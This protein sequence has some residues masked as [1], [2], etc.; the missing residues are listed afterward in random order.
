MVAGVA[1]SLLVAA[2]PARA[3][4]AAPGPQPPGPAS[5]VGVLH[6]YAVPTVMV[7][8]MFGSATGYESGSG[9]MGAFDLRVSVGGMVQTSRAWRV[10]LGLVTDLMIPFERSYE[11]T[12]VYSQGVLSVFGIEAELERTLANQW[13]IGGR[14]SG[15]VGKAETGQWLMLGARARKGSAFAGVDLLLG[16]QATDYETSKAYGVL[17]GGGLE[18]RPGRN[19]V[20]GEAGL[21]ALLSVLYV[22]V[23]QHLVD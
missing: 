10:R 6:G 9:R 22:V 7:G 8:G 2:V 20:L 16:R 13:R 1:M 18:G 5:A 14:A 21:V 4:P 15:E 23:L 12:G 19:F 11:A 3:E 17:V